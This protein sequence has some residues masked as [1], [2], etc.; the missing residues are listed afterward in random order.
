VDATSGDIGS[1]AGPALDL[2]ASD[3]TTVLQSSLPAGAG[4]SRS[5]RV[6]NATGT[7][8]DDRWVRL[9]SAG[10]VYCEA[11]DVYR[12][13][14]LDTT[15]RIARF[16]NSATQI[17]VLTLQNPTSLPVAGH[18]QFWSPAG[19]PLASLPVALPARGAFVLN[20]STV[21][22]LS[23][24]SGSITLSHDA[25][26]GALSG[27]AVALEPATGFTFDTPMLPRER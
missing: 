18:A 13:R 27:K 26:Y 8:I 22:G 3:G 4:A 1:G 7:A 15:H 21:G 14:A 19:T 9:Q 5:L 10:C 23:G 20:T 6:E 12:L 17:T 16:N 11:E 2:V 25:P 24:Q